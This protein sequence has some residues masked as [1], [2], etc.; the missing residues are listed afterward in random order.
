MKTFK[1]LVLFFPFLFVSCSWFMGSDSTGSSE[2][3]EYRDNADFIIDEIKGTVVPTSV[4]GLPEEIQILYTACFRDDEHPDNTIQNGLFKIHFFENTHN[5]NPD[6][7]S[8]ECPEKKSFLL[9]SGE[10]CIK[11][12]TDSS[13]CLKWTEIYPYSPVSDSVW[14][15][16]SRTFEGTGGGSTGLYTINM[17]VNPWLGTD[18]EGSALLLQLVDLRY[19]SIGRKKVMI[20]LEDKD[21][22]EC[23]SCPSSQ[24]GANCK[25]LCKDKKRSL[26][27]A[28]AYFQTQ[29]RRPRLWLHEVTSEISQEH[30]PVNNNQK[31]A[32]LLRRLKVCHNGIQTNCDPPGRF[33]KVRLQMPLEIK[34]KDYRG[35]PDY[36]P[37]TRGQYSI[38]P[39]LFL[40]NDQE[41]Y[42]V[43]NR[44]TGFV[45]DSLFI[46]TKKNNLISEFYVHIPY[47]HYGMPAFL[48]L[49]VQAEGK[50]KDL[51]L[52][53][54]GVF[55]FSG[56]L[57][58]IMESNNLKLEKKI[59]E[60]EKKTNG[61]AGLIN[62]YNLSGSWDHRKGFRKAG[63]HVILK[64]LRFSDIDIDKNKCPTPVD[65]HVRYVGEVCIVDPLTGELVSNTDIK[66]QR[67]N[68]LHTKS[69]VK[70][71]QVID[72]EPLSQDADTSQF[73]IKGD[74]FDQEGKEI[75]EQW[76]GVEGRP[77]TREETYNT[78]TSGCVQWVDTIYHKFYNREQYFDRKMIFSKEEWGFTGERIIA[79][80]PWHWGF[81]FFQ[82]I[83][84]LKQSPRGRKATKRAERPQIIL[85][86]F[87]SVFPELIYSID[88]LLGINIFQNILFLFK[89]RIDRPDNVASGQGSQRP[90]AMDIRRG[91]YFLRFIIVKSHTE[92]GGGQGNAVVNDTVFRDEYRQMQNWN[93]NTGWRV[94]GNGSLWGRFW[95]KNI[96]QMMNTKMEYITHYDTY[97]QIRDSTINAY[98]NFLFELGQFIYIGSN[99][100]LIAQLL[101]TDPAKYEYY[102]G[103][104]EV[105]PTRSDF[106]PYMSHELI[107][108]P[109]MGTFVSGD[110]RNWNIFRVLGEPE[111]VRNIKMD[112]EKFHSEEEENLSGLSY[113]Q[114]EQ[115]I[116]LGKK[117]SQEH[118]LFT[119]LHSK[120]VINAGLWSSK[121]RAAIKDVGDILEELYDKIGE[122][123]QES[124]KENTF[125]RFNQKRIQLTELTER[126]KSQLLAAIDTSTDKDNKD[127]LF[128]TELS[129]VVSFAN[130]LLQNTDQSSLP[131]LKKE[132]QE[133]LKSFTV[134]VG[135]YLG[136]PLS[137][138]KDLIL[139][140]NKDDMGK[141][142]NMDIVTSS[143]NPD[144]W[145]GINMTMFARD[146]GLKIIT[147]DDEPAIHQFLEDLDEI[148][149]IHNRYNEVYQKNKK[150]ETEA[151]RPTWVEGKTR[152][153][154]TLSGDLESWK[155]EYA[156]IKAGLG[157]DIH[158]AEEAADEKYKQITNYQKRFLQNFAF[159]EGD[160][161]FAMREKT[162][163]TY[164]PRGMTPADLR[165]I[166]VKG[167]H[168]ST[169]NNPE[170]MTFL[171][172]LCGFWFDKFYKNYMEQNQLDTIYDKHLDHFQYYKST[173]QYF[174]EEGL[175]NQY[176]DL[177]ATLKKYSLLSGIDQN[178]LV[179]GQNPFQVLDNE[180]EDWK[181]YLVRQAVELWDGFFSSEEQEEKN[182]SEG[183]ESPSNTVVQ[184][185]YESL[186]RIREEADDMNQ[187][188][189]MSPMHHG[190]G[191]VFFEMLTNHRHPY[192]RC[193]AN[194]LNFLHV[195][196]KIIVGDI[197]HR[198]SDLKYEYGRTASIN[199]QIAFD[200][201]YSA[202]WNMS[203]SFST[204]LGAGFTALN[205]LGGAEFPNYTNPL[206]RVNPIF[207][208]SGIDFKSQ[209]STSKS[210]SE[211]NRRQSS[212][213][214]ANEALY[215]HTHESAISVRLKNF[216][217]CLVIR[218]KNLAFDGYQEG[219]VWRD[220]LADN[221]IHQ[222]PYIKS[223]LLICSEDIDAENREDPFY[224]TE[225]YF[226]LY[227]VRPGDSQFFNLFSYRNRPF[228][229]AV[230][231]KAEME[232]LGFLMQ[233]FIEADKVEG[234]EDY[235]PFGL[236]TNPYNTVSKPAEGTQKSIEK[237]KIWDKTGFYP[238]VYSVAFDNEHYFFRDPEKR[239]PGMLERVGQWFERNNPFGFI[240][241]DNSEGITQRSTN[242]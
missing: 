50:H 233:S 167:I 44:D 238:G 134:L 32:E 203:R 123:L 113:A 12:R 226:Y 223:G 143:N 26:S 70:E 189:S 197:G 159:I 96:G 59:Y 158:F 27:A 8:K 131:L 36:L 227:Q 149:D 128:L 175:T 10:S 132:L 228:V 231:G 140:G 219:T 211:Q 71:G 199:T 80:N 174:T 13:G 181:E 111:R 133:V 64:R 98:V 85:H 87:R 151:I 68:I 171:H 126:A 210:A 35:D 201:A 110:V 40:K 7:T 200:Y 215:L 115:L 114:L 222:V 89:V 145:S 190:A 179:I 84:E 230:R 54:E 29:S 55:P 15:K 120:L 241:F 184:S 105:D 153:G 31:N 28:I 166:V 19:H 65:R 180:Y 172:S 178:M 122:L 204:S 124:Y 225:N 93:T 1:Y 207:A 129:R 236:M 106:V 147:L 69:G 86:D 161:Y 14:F 239:D 25:L 118:K 136:L 208:F 81:V 150:T 88:R 196:K 119:K 53:F 234:M 156:E 90:S 192:F 16:Y 3:E 176:N 163:Q 92:E 49:K 30:I 77:L 73:N 22:P 191:Q 48:G 144:N 116:D 63:W 182:S 240:R 142:F 173:L 58:K 34:V 242:Q 11:V 193:M 33:L 188:L 75:E 186:L 202:T 216:R 212:L 24:S 155:E 152:F 66:I 52:P 38:K 224:I 195:E 79:I 72:I 141:H 102:P 78:D 57:K 139:Q 18:P 103:T 127:R 99:N 82:D 97:V 21:I 168:P 76:Y 45:T 137:S 232:K 67:Q 214:F 185:L 101:P 109:F 117:H 94:G 218:A 135:K 62:S 43:L 162:E 47:E 205:Y 169:L 104:C 112:Q 187:A 220:D 91:Y 125:S 148:A 213:R 60:T 121:S 17:A 170:V 130:E 165:S 23:H 37:L 51:F 164:I 217:H 183:Q 160:D 177:Y 157:D 95:N 83:T 107:S 56:K 235:D 209:W 198:Y 237:A 4:N 9:S 206:N 229:L 42:I 41:Q 100:R 6:G 20:K 2:E 146:E 108:R 39:Y 46:G 221:F 154:N 194:P 74:W 5:K 61:V 138:D